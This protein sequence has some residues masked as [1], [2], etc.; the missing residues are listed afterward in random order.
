MGR[1]VRAV[2]REAYGSLLACQLL[3]AQGAWALRPRRGATTQLTAP[4]SARRALR[5][6]R[7][8][9]VAVM[10][11][12]PRASYRE[13]LGLCLRERRVR[14]TAKQKRAWPQRTPH[15]PPRPPQLLMM[16]DQEKALYSWVMAVA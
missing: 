5:E 11:R 16:S 6:V 1:T 10:P 3:L 15:V 14:T 9:L 12:A 2:H 4:C 7:R 8:E 13:R